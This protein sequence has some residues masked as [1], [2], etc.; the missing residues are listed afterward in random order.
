MREIAAELGV[1]RV[2][3]WRTLTEPTAAARLADLTARRQ[4]RAALELS[5]L[6]EDALGL[7][8]EIVRDAAAPPAVR[9]R[10]AEAVLDRAGIGPH[11]NAA[12][13]VTPAG[14][15]DGAVALLRR[16]V[17]SRDHCEAHA[18]DDA[19]DHYEA[20][21][22]DPRPAPPSATEERTPKTPGASSVAPEQQALKGPMNVRPSSRAQNEP[23][24]PPR[25]WSDPW[26]DR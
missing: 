19:R 24:I 13:S 17:E 7:L 26:G 15:S 2:T 14:P 20:H 5:E 12:V 4:R 1:H 10:A 25:P 11:M 21:D 6:V 9:L 16:L 23:L 8:G 18:P 3:V 22:P